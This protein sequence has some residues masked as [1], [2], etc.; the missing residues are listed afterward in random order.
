MS[1]DKFTLV[2]RE[3]EA[4]GLIKAIDTQV[5]AFFEILSTVDLD[6]PQDEGEAYI[7]CE[8]TRLRRVRNRLAKAIRWDNE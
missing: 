8:A 2:L 1:K 5:E 6:E 7:V 4:I 3:N